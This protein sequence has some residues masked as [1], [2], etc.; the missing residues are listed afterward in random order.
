[1]NERPL[2][3]RRIVVTRAAEQAAE[4]SQ[5]LEEQ[6]AEPIIVSL[7]EIVEPS[8]KGVALASAL[9]HLSEYDWLI[10]TSPNGETRV[11]EAIRSAGETRPRLAA[12][13]TTTATALGCD[14]DLVPVR[15]SADGMVEGFPSGHGRVLIA[16][17]E[18]A[19]E[20]LGEGI[21]GKGWTVDVVPAYRTKSVTPSAATLLAVLAADAVLFASGSAVRSWVAAFGVQ[22]PPFV[23]AIGPATADVAAGFGLKIDAISADHSVAGLVSALLTTLGRT[24]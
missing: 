21:A 9:D 3:G 4:L 15:Q 2:A 11:A 10:V 5:L 1:M 20:G 16:Q 23:V 7:I 24:D 12:V 13:G 17:S 14:V 8:D 6:G 19:K 22:T 18:I